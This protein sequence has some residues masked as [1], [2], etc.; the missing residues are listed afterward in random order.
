MKRGAVHALRASALLALLALVTVFAVASRGPSTD[1]E[2]VVPAGASFSTVSDTLT[3]RGVVSGARLFRLF[4]R[5]RGDDRSIKSGRYL[6]PAGTGW[7][8]VLTA[9]TE[10]RVVTVPLTI[11]EGFWLI[12]MAPRIAEVSG[13]AVGDVSALL[14]A[15]GA[16]T[17]YGVP[18]PGLE[19]YLFPDTYYFARG[20]SPAT[21]VETMVERYRQAWTPA[22]RAHLDSLDL[23]EREIVT[24]AS[25]IQS[26]ARVLDEM[27]V[28]SSVYHNRLERGWPLQAD[29]TVIYALGARRERLLFAAIDS[30]ADHL[31]NTYT[32]PGLPPGPI[33]APGDL[34]I[35]AALHPADTDFMYFVARPDGSHAF[36]RTL[37]EHNREREESRRQLD[38]MREGRR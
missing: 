24:L 3:A 18:G 27:P 10:G 19:G 22:R 38:A 31:Y 8:R 34:A 12:D 35:E 33:G 15:P 26:E 11:P 1:V 17:L 9:L 25:I 37:A 20:V 16:D 6:I 2:F 14:Q 29:P 4:A 13:A 7:H 28:I 23:D 5:V 32:Q 36:T 21:V 30:V